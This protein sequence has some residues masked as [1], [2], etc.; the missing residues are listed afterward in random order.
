MLG[1]EQVLGRMWHEHTVSKTY[2]PVQLGEILAKRS[3]TAAGEVNPLQKQTKAVQ[4]L[5]VQDDQIIQEEDEK[6]WTPRSMLAVMD[7][8]NS[9]RWAWILLQIEE[10]D[11]VHVHAICGL[12]HTEAPS[13]TNQARE[14]PHVLGVG[15]MEDGHG[16][17]IGPILPRHLNRSHGRRGL[18]E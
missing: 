18:A 15:R 12:V 9:I 14:P 17:A 8:V 3:F 13:A 16:D 5:R 1:A 7:G 4:M 2:A 6:S 11:H 10:E